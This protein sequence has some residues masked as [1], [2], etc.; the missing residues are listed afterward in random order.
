LVKPRLTTLFI[1]WNLLFLPLDLVFSFI[2]IPGLLLALAGVYW[3][4]G[5]MTLAILPLA[6]LGNIVIYRIQNEMAKDERLQIRR[7]YVGLF[8]Y[9]FAYSLVMQP[10]CVWGYASELTG[11]KKQWGTK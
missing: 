5:P 8:F 2:F 7:S 4:A 11:R 9:V 6:A 1:W 3:I 10:I